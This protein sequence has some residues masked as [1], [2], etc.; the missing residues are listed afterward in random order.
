MLLWHTLTIASLVMLALPVAAQTSPAADDTGAPQ[1]QVLPLRSAEVYA[2]PPQF[3]YPPA[4]LRAEIEGRCMISF[5]IDAEGVPQDITPDCDHP[6]FT[7]P[8]RS[9]VARVRMIVG[10]RFVAGEKF[11]LPVSFRIPL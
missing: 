3:D 6:L 7:E 8:A 9:G 1:A 2:V 11:R 10:G 5:T 4:A